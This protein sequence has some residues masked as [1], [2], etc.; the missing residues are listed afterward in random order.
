M[1]YRR[2]WLIPMLAALAV[3]GLVCYATFIDARPYFVTE[4][5]AEQDYYYNARLILAGLPTAVHHPGT[6]VQYLASALLALNGEGLQ[7]VQRF[8]NVV[9]LV[10]GALTSLSFFLFGALAGRQSSR[11]VMALAFA[12]VLAWPPVLTYLTVLGADSFL[13]T[14]GLP[15]LAIFWYA[16]SH[17]ARAKPALLLLG[18][19]GIGLCLAVKMS[20]V[21]VAV[22]LLAGYSTWAIRSTS[23][24][25]GLSARIRPLRPVLVGAVGGYLL[26][27][28]PVVKR[29]GVI[30]FRTANRADVSPAGASPWHE[31]WV[32][33]G[34]LVD[35][36]PEWILLLGTTVLM[37]AAL[38]TMH[39]LKRA[40]GS[41]LEP[42]DV[43]RFDFV[44][45]GVF[46]GLMALAFGYTAS[47]APS[48]TPGAEAGIRLRNITPTA[49]AAPFL[50]LYAER[51]HLEWSE[52]RGNR[53]AAELIF[54][55]LATL[56]VTVA[57]TRHLRSRHEFV[58][59]HQHQIAVTESRMASLAGDGGRVAFWTES[60]H[61]YLGAA[62]FH[63]W[64]NY[65]YANHA[66]DRLLLKWFPR[67]TFLRLRTLG[68]TYQ[69]PTTPPVS[70]P[71][72]SRYGRLG[73]LYWRIRKALTTDRPHYN[74]FP[75]LLAGQGATGPIS[76]VAFPEEELNEIGDMDERE[77][78]AT[79]HRE[80]GVTLPWRER[81]GTVTWILFR[82]PGSGSERRSAPGP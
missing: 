25:S 62:S 79:L 72:R 21:P 81:I 18:G 56:V 69:A 76:A 65:R 73:D 34:L 80:L 52:R 8:F 54:F 77:L 50:F 59:R 74:S 3:S 60:S 78:A 4:I 48:I 35:R 32:T 45:A 14:S 36:A 66:F 46:L 16:L 20:F 71:G 5:D 9:Y 39:L 33:V 53:A 43:P 26:A 38:L 2:W 42:A 29:I 40:D 58:E 75:E 19:V 64:G 63:F 15:T 67:Y 7:V 23:G 57:F 13:V 68:R 49:L 6:P 11:G 44:A 47:A 51:L 30:W 12:S 27:I 61:D 10:I 28:A 22:A 24:Q 70:L 31:A 1:E 82:A 55:G 41:P 37:L 17:R